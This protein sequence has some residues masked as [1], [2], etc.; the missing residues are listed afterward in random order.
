VC[1][2]CAIDVRRWLGQDRLNLC[3]GFIFTFRCSRDV[4]LFLIY[5]HFQA[6]T[7]RPAIMVPTDIMAANLC[8]SSFVFRIVTMVIYFFIVYTPQ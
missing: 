6:T 2:A 8:D 4:K 3:F 7:A 5:L 1:Y